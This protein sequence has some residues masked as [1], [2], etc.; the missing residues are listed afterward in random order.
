VLELLLCGYRHNNKHRQVPVHPS[1]L[2]ALA[3]YAQVRDRACPRPGS[4][5]FFVSKVGTRLVHV[6]VDRSFAQLARRAGLPRPGTA[7]SPRLH[8]LRHFF[9]VSTVTAWYRAGLD[10]NARLPLLSTYMGH[11]DPANSYWYLSATPELLALAAE[12][13]DQTRSGRP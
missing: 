8:D 1:T 9:A 7:R 4:T 2:D 10:V 12:R 6:N 13:R 5:T 11:A 3:A